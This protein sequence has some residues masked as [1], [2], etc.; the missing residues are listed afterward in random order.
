MEDLDYLRL[1][2]DLA[3]SHSRDGRHGP[4]GAVVVLDGEVVGRGWNR[5]VEARDPTAHAEVTAIREA[6]QRLETHDLSGSTLYASCEPCPMCLA[7][8][9]WARIRRV[10]FAASAE[11]ATAAKFD[12]TWIRRE[13]EKGW[14]S[15][16]V[17]AVQALREEG[18]RV[19]EAWQENPDRVPY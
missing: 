14:E 6:A 7:A 17:E 1:A 16:E 10:V 8:L 3:S 13:L 12:D 9:Y 4:F 2:I 5:V 18:R 11:D 19:L 15:R